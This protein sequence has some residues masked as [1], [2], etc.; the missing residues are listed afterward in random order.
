[1][2]TS[3]LSVNEM[4]CLK[5]LGFEPGEM[6]VGNSVYSIGF[7]GSLT[8]G[9][10]GLIGG[11]INAITDMISS[12][13]HL[14][15]NRLEQEGLDKGN[16][17]VTGVS[18]ELIQHS[19]AG[20]IEFLSI[21]SGVKKENA[22]GQKSFFS[23]SIDGEE[24]FCNIDAGYNPQKF[25]MGNVAYSIGLGGG[26]IGSLKTLGRGEIKEYSNIFNHTRHL[27]LERI[28]NEA[29]KTGA[30][31]VLN[32]NTQIFPFYNGSSSVTEMLMIGT[33][34]HN[35]ALGPEYTQNPVTSDLCSSEL[36]S[37]TKM[38]YIPLKL[39][40][41]TAVYSLGL[42]GG[43]TS[44][45]KS[46]VKG[47]IKE[48]TTM[49]YDAREHAIGLIED[50]AKNLGA[51]LVVGTKIYMYELSNNLIEFMAIGT[52]VKKV[53]NVSTRSEELIPQAIIQDRD[54]YFDNQGTSFGSNGR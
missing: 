42:V 32:I 30:N 37:L 26:F 48:L 53:S 16:Q 5:K 14:A 22:D 51:D 31:S 52:A 19:S 8:S 18:T 15:I 27:A 6:V 50:E 24:L 28:V 4:Y 33:A 35:Q 38:G 44:M 36:W 21:G 41:G 9:F 7:M 34:S 12:G 17:G 20:N 40:L 54:T 11:E 1:M 10:R 47:E 46:F 2:F 45:L 39:V 3:D 49:V 29:K 25:V 23:S 43:I 13:R